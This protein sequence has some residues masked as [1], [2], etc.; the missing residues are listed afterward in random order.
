MGGRKVH[1][2]NQPILQLDAAQHVH[3]HV[4]GELGLYG[5]VG[6]D[7]NLAVVKKVSEGLED[8]D[9]SKLGGQAGIQ[10]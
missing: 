1:Q 9:D 10:G 8:N 7:E 5:G 6:D 3:D 4:Y 2:L